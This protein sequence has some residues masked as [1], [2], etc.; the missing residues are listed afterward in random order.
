MQKDLD[1]AVVDLNSSINQTAESINLEVSKKVGNNEIISKI[2]QSAEKISIDANKISLEGYTTINGSFSVDEKGNVTMTEGKISLTDD[3]INQRE[4]KVHIAGQ[5]FI[6]GVYSEGIVVRKKGS[7]TS[8]ISNPSIFLF[9]YNDEPRINM[10]GSNSAFIFSPTQFQTRLNTGAMISMRDGI[11]FTGLSN[12]SVNCN[13]SQGSLEEMKKNIKKYSENV[14]EKIRKSDIYTYN[15]KLETDKEKPH[16]GF[17]I[18][19]NY[20]TP[21]EII[22]KNNDGID[23]YSMISFLWKGVQELTKKVEE[24]EEKLN[25]KN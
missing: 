25:E 19:E 17:I 13:I 23:L 8:S 22:S 21:Q 6:N 7:S 15:L 2:N 3:G 5:T 10:T 12:F 4:G 16:I 24:L 1:T 9:M 14:I 20:N 18:G 11:I